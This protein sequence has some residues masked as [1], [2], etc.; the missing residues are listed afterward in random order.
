MEKSEAYFTQ[1][2]VFIKAAY[3][4]PK[5]HRHFAPRLL[6]GLEGPLELSV[7]GRKLEAEGV[8][9]GSNVLH[10]VLSGSPALV[11]FAHE[12]TDVSVGMKEKFLSGRRFCALTAADAEKL[13]CCWN[14]GKEEEKPGG[15]QEQAAAAQGGQ[16]KIWRAE[17]AVRETEELLRLTQEPAHIV[18]DRV[19]GAAEYID[20][21]T[22]LDTLTVEEISLAVHLSVSRLS[23][24][25]KLETG[26]SL[27]L[28]LANMKLRRALWYLLQGKSVVVACM[29]AGF[30]S[31]SHF[32]DTSRKLYGMSAKGLAKNLAPVWI[33]NTK[34][35]F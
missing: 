35:K 5:E 34:N 31:P 25:F 13:R 15:G 24:L 8:V 22:E 3:H 4:N 21:V 28:Y 6:L 29:D 16:E 30:A 20:S 2:C 32:A 9:I 11:V 17:C 26:G 10:T 1:F 18:D 23:H 19:K 14:R 7:A 27:K 33:Q 12:L